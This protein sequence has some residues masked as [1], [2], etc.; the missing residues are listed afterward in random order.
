[1]AGRTSAICGVG[2]EGVDVVAD[3][4]SITQGR[5]SAIEHAKPG[6]TELRTLCGRIAIQARRSRQSW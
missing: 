6:T 4:M 2:G 5:V 1:M 3:R